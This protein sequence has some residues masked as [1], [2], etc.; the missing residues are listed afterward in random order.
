MLSS[1]WFLFCAMFALVCLTATFAIAASGG[2]KVSATSINCGDSTKESNNLTGANRADVWF[3][4]PGGPTSNIT[5]W[6]TITCRNGV[7]EACDD[8]RLS[9]CGSEDPNYYTDDFLLP[10]T[11][12]TRCTF[13]LYANSTCTSAI[14]S[15]TWRQ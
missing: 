14:S 1:R 11:T 9:Y 15:D 7:S 6:Y 10:N 2:I 13:T 3:N 8:I 5:R 4:L 12:G